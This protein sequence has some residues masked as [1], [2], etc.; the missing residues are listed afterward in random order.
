MKIEVNITKKYFYSILVIIILVGGV[1]V[2]GAFVYPGY[3]GNG[4][5]PGHGGTNVWVRTANG[6][7]TLQQAIDDGDLL[8]APNHIG[9]CRTITKTFTL[10]VPSGVVRGDNCNGNEFVFTCSTDLTEDIITGYYGSPGGGSL[11]IHYYT[12]SGD[13][14]MYQ[15]CTLNCAGSSCNGATGDKHLYTTCCPIIP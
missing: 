3:T 1:L 4:P 15:G 7:K 2:V 5:D 12:T 10:T 6:E 9:E 11:G 8:E 14:K 13:G